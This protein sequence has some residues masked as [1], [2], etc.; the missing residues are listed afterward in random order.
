M[1]EKLQKRGEIN[2]NLKTDFDA[3]IFRSFK[4]KLKNSIVVLP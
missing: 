4:S 1:I 3:M 2:P